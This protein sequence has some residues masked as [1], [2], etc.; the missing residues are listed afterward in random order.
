MKKP[1]HRSLLAVAVVLIGGLYLTDRV[2]LEKRGI[3][4]I[5]G[6]VSSTMG[7]DYYDLSELSEP[8]FLKAFKTAMIRGLQ[9]NKSS[10]GVGIS[11]GIF[12]VKNDSG[13]K[14]YACEKYPN[15]EIILQA[16]G[17]A[18]SG[19]IPTLSVRGP[20]MV[21]DDGRRILP[22]EIPL[23]GLPQ[24]LR[25]NPNYQVALGDRGESFVISA[26]DLYSDYWPTDW[27]VVGIKLS[28][29]QEVLEIDGYEII[30]LLDQ[31]LTLD[32]T[33]VE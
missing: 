12:Q 10:R 1:K 16:D 25:E 30:S 33:K 17:V 14:V 26:Q 22:L 15:L 20:C 21:S 4:S 2:F 31:P 9:V 13:A 28:N 5:S 18:N 11:L 23:K 6:A 29:D 27:N 8:E 32:F 3:A 24:K 7:R 19:N